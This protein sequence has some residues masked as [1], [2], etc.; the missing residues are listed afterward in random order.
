MQWKVSPDNHLMELQRR[1]SIFFSAAKS[2]I[3]RTRAFIACQLLADTGRLKR[4]KKSQLARVRSI[5][6]FVG[7]LWPTPCI[8]T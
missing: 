8:R 1:S 6:S 5:G 3:S 4:L 7:H 2:R